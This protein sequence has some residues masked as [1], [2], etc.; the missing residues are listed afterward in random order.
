ME[1]P[2][3]Y[4]PVLVTLHWLIVLLV[5]ANLFLGFF[6]I[7]PVL[8][9]G[10]G[11]RVPDSIVT[12]HMAVGIAILVLLVVRL[13]VR[14]GSGKPAAATSGNNFVDILARVI[15]YALYFFVFAITVV[16]LV[17]A[18]QTNRLQRAFFGG[19]PEFAGPRNGN[20]GGFPTPGP[21]TPQPS[22]GGFPTRGP[23]TP[24]P[25]FGGGNNPGFGGQAGGNPGFSGN[26][27]RPGGPGGRFGLVFLLLPLHLDIA[28]VLAVLIGLHILAALYH[29]FILK[30]NLIARMWYGKA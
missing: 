23:G 8:R 14:I 4:H 2:K 27:P 1:T 24:R 7:E 12:I 3:R 9:G 18:L 29:Q 10:G 15:H 6:E 30:D 5:L 26:G 16:G 13:F 22:F 11:F 28:I 19:G 17:F 20:F 21:G 25:S